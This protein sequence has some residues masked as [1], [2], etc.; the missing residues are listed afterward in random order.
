MDDE[1]LE[2]SLGF[3]VNWETSMHRHNNILISC[4]SKNNNFLVGLIKE[5]NRE[6]TVRN[7]PAVNVYDEDMYI[8]LDKFYVTIYT[9][10]FESIHSIN[11]PS[12]IIV[13][14]YV[15]IEEDLILVLVSHTHI[16]KFNTSL[17]YVDENLELLVTA[18]ILCLT[19]ECQ[20]YLIDEKFLAYTFSDNGWNTSRVVNIVTGE[21]VGHSVYHQYS[22]L[23]YNIAYNNG[24]IPMVIL[25]TSTTDKENMSS[26]ITSLEV[27]NATIT[28]FSSNKTTDP[29]PENHYFLIL[30]TVPPCAFILFVIIVIVMLVVWCNRSN[31]ME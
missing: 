16:F 30:Y 11:T 20:S 1:N 6:V 27:I 14:D 10:E 18:T 29:I 4:P 23:L 15:R 19:G 8:T 31:K 3:C 24:S 21:H 13:V 12:S 7:S 9:N 17:P 28:Y 2:E 5:Q 26:S 25:P 22:P